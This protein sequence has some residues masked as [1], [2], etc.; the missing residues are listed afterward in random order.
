MKKR[1]KELRKKLGLTQQKFADRLGLK[2]QT[3]A[4]YEMG[5][6]TPSD[7]TLLLI[8]KEFNINEEWLR[9]GKGEMYIV[10]EDETAILVTDMIDNTDS[11]FYSSILRI[12]KIYKELDPKSQD[13][14]DDLL[15]RLLDD[16]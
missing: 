4:A 14:I 1:I 15:K 3:I 5:N 12:M 2:R 10:P 8:C 9:T 11:P 6:I 13:V 16:K 7:S